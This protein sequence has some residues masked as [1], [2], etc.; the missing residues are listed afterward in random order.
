[1][2]YRIMGFIILLI[3]TTQLIIQVVNQVI[4]SIIKPKSLPKMDYTTKISEE[5]STMVVIPTIITSTLKVKEVFDKLETFYLMNKSPLSMRI[6]NF[7]PF[8]PATFI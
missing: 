3:P 6:K 5:S 7:F 2:E 1:M 8:P 4:Q